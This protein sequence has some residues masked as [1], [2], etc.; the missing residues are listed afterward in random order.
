[1]MAF[2]RIVATMIF[3]TVATMMF[4]TVATMMFATV[5]TV[6]FATVATM[7][8]VTVA[9]TF[10]LLGFGE[11]LLAPPVES[12]LGESTALVVA[13]ILDVFYGPGIL[14]VSYGPTSGPQPFNDLINNHTA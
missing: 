9:I 5:A 6:M 14:D 13:G 12:L 11:A 7:M 10:P 1:M 4:A 2:N 8:F 3:S